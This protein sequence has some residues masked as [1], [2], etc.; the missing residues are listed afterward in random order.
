VATNVTTHDGT[1][2]RA[3]QELAVAAWIH[4][5]SAARL[6]RYLVAGTN[7][8]TVQAFNET[9]ESSDFVFNAQLYM[10]QPDTEVVAARI[11]RHDPRT[12][13][14]SAHQPHRHLLRAGHER[15]GRQPA[16]QR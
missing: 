10:F 6:A 15:G 12:G 4:N 3:A 1:A 11:T 14:S 2:S 5:P 9:A 8:L 16:D 7:V 13:M